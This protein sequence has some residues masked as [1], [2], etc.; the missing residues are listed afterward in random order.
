MLGSSRT[1]NAYAD[2]YVEPCP[3]HRHTYI[4][5]SIMHNHCHCCGRPL[6]SRVSSR[7]QS[8]PLQR[9]KAIWGWWQC[10]VVSHCAVMSCLSLRIPQ[11]VAVCCTARVF[12]VVYW[13]FCVHCCFFNRVITIVCWTVCVSTFACWIVCVQRCVE[14]HLCVHRC[15][16]FCVFAVVCWI[17]ACSALFVELS[18]WSALFVELSLPSD[19]FVK[20]CSASYVHLCLLNF[21]CLSVVCWTLCWT[22]YVCSP[23]S[24]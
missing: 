18:V 16:T 19:V 24:V 23:S 8:Y 10:W 17:F 6:S 11:K 9:Y 1:C 13:S 5:Y 22:S 21:L 14:L 20:A 2:R 15:P 4:C 12:T 3:S 7:F